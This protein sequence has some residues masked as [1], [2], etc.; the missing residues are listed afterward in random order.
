[1]PETKK[2]MHPLNLPPTGTPGRGFNKTESLWKGRDGVWGRGSGLTVPVLAI[3]TGEGS[4]GGALGLGVANHILMLE[5]AVYSVLSPEGFAS[6]LWK[7]ASRSGEACTMM[8]LTA[9]YCAGA[10]DS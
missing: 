3:V 5:N 4:S 6:I 7:D 10:E 9:Q 1:M 2:P 8:K